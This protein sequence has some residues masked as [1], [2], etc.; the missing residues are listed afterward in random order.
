MAMSKFLEKK[1]LEYVQIS[2]SCREI[3]EKADRIPKTHQDRERYV[4]QKG[5]VLA[6]FDN[7]YDPSEDLKSNKI[8][9]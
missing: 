6:I 1:A 4:L 8:L 7:Q 9:A 5:R 3:C 2:K